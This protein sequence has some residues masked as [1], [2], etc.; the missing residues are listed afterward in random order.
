MCY[1]VRRR[2]PPAAAQP[3]EAERSSTRAEG[4]LAWG[5]DATDTAG[6]GGEAPAPVPARPGGES[7]DGP[8]DLQH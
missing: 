6:A 2:E 1:A 7:V 4:W 5:M 8:D 3:R